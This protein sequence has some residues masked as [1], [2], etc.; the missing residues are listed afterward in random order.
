MSSTDL[1][2]RT[3]LVTGASRGF[4][5]AIACELSARGARV[6]GVARHRDPLE[7][8]HDELG[9]RF[10]PVVGDASNAELARSLIEEHRPEIL[11]LNAGAVPVPGSLREHTWKS[12]SRNWEVDT[13]HV[14][15]WTREALRLPLAPGSVVI[16]MSSG[17]ALHGSPLSGGYA[18]AKATIRFISAYAAE[19]SRRDD[20]GI[21]FTALLPQ[22]TPA[23]DVG[24]AGAAAYAAYEG[25]SIDAFVERF[26]PLLS[27]QQV[28]M[29]VVELSRDA[30]LGGEHRL[31]YALSG[32]GCHEIRS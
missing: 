2:Q 23:T 24:A 25:L 26:Q 22:L 31:A 11:V 18:G 16:A 14:F 8:L 30:A 10:L 28:G 4:G 6:I 15:H 20:L 19:E 13:Q 5:R 27:A 29:A 32:A 12:F 7:Q 3:A 21:R 1:R 9:E 17:A